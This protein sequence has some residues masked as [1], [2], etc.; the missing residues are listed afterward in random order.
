MAMA[1]V[2]FQRLLQEEQN[3]KFFDKKDN[4]MVSVI[5]FSL[6]VPGKHYDN[7]SVEVRQPC[8]SDYGELMEVSSPPHGYPATAPWSVANFNPLCEKYCR[9]CVGPQASGIRLG[10]GATAMRGNKIWVRMEEEFDIP[11]DGSG[12][13]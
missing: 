13:W 2:T 9:R 5:T 6:D 10:G 12:A 3:Y 7:L 4:F 11:A 1:K 8:G